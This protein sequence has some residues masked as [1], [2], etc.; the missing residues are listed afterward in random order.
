[1]H[2][3]LQTYRHQLDEVDRRLLEALAARQAIIDEIAA[4]KAMSRGEL[5]DFQREEE[6][7]TRM[8]DQARKAGLNDYFVRSLFH[9]ILDYSVRY[10]IDHLA[11]HDHPERVV[12]AYQGSEGAYGHLAALHHFSARPVKPVCHGYPTLR[13]AARAVEAGDAGYAVLPVENTT[14]GSINETY[15]L[16]AQT[17]LHLVAEEVLKVEHCLAAIEPVPLR[18]IRRISADP[19][20]IAQCST[21]L[22]TLSDCHVES[23]PDTARAARQV[24]DEKD[25]SHAAITTEEVARRYGLHV[26]KRHIANQKEVYTR[27]F[28]VAGA[29]VAYDTRIP[30]KTSLV[31][32]TAHEKG[33][34]LRCLNVLAE[35]GLNLTKLESRP[36][37][38]TPWE[39]L[40]YVDF[41]GNVA[42]AQ[43]EAAL[44]VL[45]AETPYLK[46]L[47]SYPIRAVPQQH[48]PPRALPN[49]RPAKPVPPPA[50]KPAPRTVV[51]EKK[52]Y[53]LASRAHRPHDTLIQVGPVTIGGDVPVLIAGP[54][55]VESKEQIMA[56]AEA[57]HTLGG[58]ILR[59]GCFKPRTSPYAFQGLGY[60]GLA[61]LAE[62]GRAYGLPVVTEVLHPADVAAVAREADILQIGARNMQNFALLKEVG[63]AGRPVLLKRGMMASIDEWLSAAEYILAHGNPNVILC[64]RGIRT[65]ETATR[66][67]LDLS[68]VP[69]VRERTHLP[70]IVDPSHA[71]GT[72]R[73]VVPM[74]RAALAA[75]AHGVMVE[76]HPEPERA[77]SDGPQSLTFETFRELAATFYQTT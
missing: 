44:R 58:H 32:A 10:Q 12:V 2:E 43:V 20:D 36:R 25:L 28:I 66:N 17:S 71:C 3:D 7:L 30:C 1:M 33:A 23:C 59:G 76:I 42:E 74:A 72:W 65:F 45:E 55:S 49:G 60:E 35:H 46:V 6:I 52:P 57:V 26:L 9:Q 31:F 24:R 15:D 16:L 37:T 19:Q 40:F 61:L 13:E 29:P 69:V 70:V 51:H 77:L 4:L 56:C 62:A 5:R 68:A 50:P 64:E 11:G 34:L 14:A 48:L 54:C 73:W 8:S 18:L 47:G 38:N 63:Q 21:F 75:G 22:A 41:E 27:F 67:T 53:R 39:Y